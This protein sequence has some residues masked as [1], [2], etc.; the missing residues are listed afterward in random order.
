MRIL[1]DDQIFSMQHHGGISRY[2][3]S[4]AKALEKLDDVEVVID[5]KWTRNA[6]LIDWDRARPLRPAFLN[7]E[8]V[9][10]PLNRITPPRAAEVVH[11]TYYDRSYLAQYEKPRAVTVHDMIPEMFPELFPAGNPHRDKH[12]FVEAAD[13]IFCV[14]ATTREDLQREY[15]P[16]PAPSIVTHLGVQDSFAP[17]LRPLPALPREYI[18]FV[19]IRRAYKDFSVLLRAVE[20]LSAKYPDLHLVAVGGGQP[21]QLE[22]SRW[23]RSSARI[24]HVTLSDKELPHAYANAKA[25]VLPS[26]YE[27]FGL[28]AL[29]A[30]ASG[31]PVLL[32]DGPTLREVGGEA[33]SY[34]RAGDSAALTE[35]LERILADDRYSEEFRHRAFARSQ[36]FSWR[37]TADKTL[38]GYAIAANKR[39][40]YAKGSR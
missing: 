12:A 9:L 6:Y 32:A 38:G 39:G 40:S 16:L 1:M 10:K 5:A 29:E 17:G 15:G 2:H 33:A 28:P 31:A 7:R 24:V 26:R 13:V 27:G 37:D 30:M 11:H 36:K 22:Q 8:R 35:V 4:L 20:R 3:I 19:G 14:S 21:T 18:L 25:F 34:F 23:G